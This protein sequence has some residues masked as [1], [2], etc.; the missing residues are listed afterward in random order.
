MYYVVFLNKFKKNVI[1]PKSWILGIDEHEENFINNSINSN[2]QFLCYFTSNPAAFDE[3]MCPKSDFAPN[4]SANMV[5]EANKNGTFDGCFL[6]KLKK[7]KSM[8]TYSKIYKTIL[9]S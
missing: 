5:N 7:Y 1:L 6:G 2:H 4:F 9:F 3:N 8:L